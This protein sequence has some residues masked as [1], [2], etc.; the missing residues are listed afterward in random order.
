M[1]CTPSIVDSLFCG[2]EGNCK[3]LSGDAC[4][5]ILDLGKVN[6]DYEVVS[7]LNLVF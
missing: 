3:E 5:R 7:E 6:I 4:D 1:H 2:F